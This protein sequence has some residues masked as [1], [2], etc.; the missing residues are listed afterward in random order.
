MRW[1][2]SLGLGFSPQRITGR[3][4]NNSSCVERLRVHDLE[5]AVASCFLKNAF[6]QTEILVPR[7]LP[8]QVGVRA[9]HHLGV[10]DQV[11]QMRMFLEVIEDGGDDRFQFGAQDRRPRPPRSRSVIW[12]AARANSAIYNSSLSLK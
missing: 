1:A 6:H 11:K 10:L 4:L 9:L 7:P 12:Q 2:R 3:R 8:R 5:S